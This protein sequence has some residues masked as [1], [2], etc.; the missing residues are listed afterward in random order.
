MVRDGYLFRAVFLAAPAV[1]AAGG[2]AIAQ[3]MAEAALAEP[4]TQLPGDAPPP[5]DSSS[6]AKWFAPLPDIPMPGIAALLMTRRYLE[7][8]HHK[9]V[10]L[11]PA[12]P[13]TPLSSTR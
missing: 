11:T 12:W 2:I 7:A 8:H 1:L 9:A 13:V 3:E 6:D 10:A 4:A 5:I